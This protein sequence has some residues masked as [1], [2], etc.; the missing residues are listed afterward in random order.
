MKI[1]EKIERF[2]GEDNRKSRFY[3]FTPEVMIATFIIEMILAVYVLV[4]YKMSSFSRSAAALVILL[5]GFQLAEYKICTDSDFLFWPVFGFIM[6]TILPVLGLRL[7]SLVTKTRHFLNIGYLAMISFMVFF[8]LSPQ[9]NQNVMCGGNYI[10]FGTEE[11][12]AMLYAI[13]YFL[14]LFLGIFEVVRHER[15]ETKNIS[16][17]ILAGYLSFILPTGIVYL[18]SPA[19]RQAV[20]SIMCGFAIFFALILALKAVP[21]Y[22]KR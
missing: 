13:Y 10:I 16:Y 3:C 9:T 15:K 1:L 6:I 18:M 14:F 12:V 7:I 22:Y 19:T 8:I 5:A 20:P 11:R 21:A 17:W 4:R 2:L